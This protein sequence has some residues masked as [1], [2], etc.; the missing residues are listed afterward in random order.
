LPEEAASKH[1]RY[2]VG[3]ELL[4][5]NGVS[6][7]VWAPRRRCV[8]VVLDQSKCVQLEPEPGGYF[9]G[10]V[11]EASHGTRYRFRLDGGDSFPDPASRFQPEGPHGPSQVIDPVRFAWSDSAWKGAGLHG[12]VVY[13]MHA[14]TFTREGT[15]QAARREL[16]ELAAL[17]ITVI[18]LMPVSEFSG[19]FGW[20]YDGVGWF[21]P[22]HHYGE[23]DDLR[24]FVDDAHREEIAVILDV[25]YNHFGP[26]GNYLKEFAEQYFT[27]RYPNEWGEAIHF[28]G[29]DSAPVREFVCANAAYWADE[30]HFDGLRLDAT[31]QIFDSSAEYIVCALGKSFRRAAGARKTL[32]VAENE[33]QH[34]RLA[35]PCEQGGDGLDCLWNDDFHH[36]ARV[37]ATGHRQA[38]YTDYRGTPQELISAVKYGYLFQG[39][40]Y[41]WQKQ[42]RGTPS[43][44]MHPEQFINYV[45]NHDQIANSG[46]GERLHRL[47]S[48]GRY[49]ALSALLLLAPNT[50]ML[51]QGQE[52]AA[53]APFFYFAD[54][55]PELRKLVREGRFEFLSQ[56]PGL[57]QSEMRP[58]LNDPGDESTFERS[59]LDFGERQ[60]HSAEYSLYRDLI[61]L[62]R[63]DPVF[64]SP[65]PYGVDGAVLG[66]EA[67]VLRF[68]ERPGA[69]AGQDR[70]L[71]INLGSDLLLDPAPDPLLAP[72]EGSSWKIQWSSEEPRYGGS[73]T[74]PLDES[75]AWMIPGHSALVMT[76][77]L[78]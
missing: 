53:S 71:L 35:R 34:T 50:P 23:P 20:G 37:A 39:Q 30:F 31:Q 21:A 15:W 62:R 51:F 17:G 8:D 72:P 64:R 22:Y 19:R 49:R 61:R 3:A 6:F 33:T 9:S 68:F 24:G 28:D 14:G 44:G 52:F 74:A 1:R 40:R 47:T 18:E 48:P 46:R 58:Y 10:T 57:S 4:P 76:P 26:D 38:Y 43:W 36:A 11:S 2:P 66:P 5:E 27:G 60:T 67:F 69:I 56:F 73:G 7:R 41:T 42:P 63:E 29:P 77:C 45:Q 25:V 13:E 65:Q 78:N 32:L 16:P 55:N 54:H 70:L 75:A 12:Q 59:K